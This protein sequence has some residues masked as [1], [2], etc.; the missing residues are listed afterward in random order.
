MVASI[1]DTLKGQGLAGIW[2]D[3]VEKHLLPR[4]FGFE[5]LMAP[6][7]ICH[8]NLALE[9]TGIDA[10]AVTPYGE[11]LNVFLTNTLDE[12]HAP[13]SGQLVLLAQALAR[14]SR[15]ADAV[16]RDKP[17]MVVLG[18]PPYSGHSANTGKWIR[19]LLRGKDGI[20]ATGSYFQV[21][22]ARLEERN[23]KWLNDDY[24]K[25]IR[26]AQRRD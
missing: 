18:N 22:G 1:R 17:V 21:D 25:F 13:S 16:K 20:E 23:P 26:Y 24:V 11:R 5:L 8:L 3:Y 7:A 15:S 9:I 2:P 10:G 4:L 14:E 6:Y 19:Q 12:P